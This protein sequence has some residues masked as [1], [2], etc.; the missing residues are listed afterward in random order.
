LYFYMAKYASF[1]KQEMYRS[2][3]RSDRADDP[4][5][6]MNTRKKGDYYAYSKD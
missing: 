2:L 4:S 3:A 5:K 6:A 1:Q